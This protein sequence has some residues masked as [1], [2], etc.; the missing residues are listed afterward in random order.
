[1][2]I[3]KSDK[4]A[5]IQQQVDMAVNTLRQQH[6]LGPESVELVLMTGGMNDVGLPD[7][8]DPEVGTEVLRVRTREIYQTALTGDDG[9]LAKT[10]RVFPKAKIIYAGN[11]NILSNA[12]SSEVLLD[13]FPFSRAKSAEDL[14]QLKPQLVEQSTAFFEESNKQIKLAISKLEKSDQARLKFVIPDFKETDSIQRGK[15][16]YSTAQPPA[17]YTLNELYEFDEMLQARVE[18]CKG[19]VFCDYGSVGHPT[20]VGAT[21]YARAIQKA[22]LPFMPTWIISGEMSS[23][24]KTGQ[25]KEKSVTNMYG[26][27]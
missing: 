27:L 18:I 2:H 11:Y 21:K 26:G 5:A 14:H 3:N 25:K 17:L 15:V 23:R 4:V 8:L 7:I 6:D 10:A 13:I 9:L 19:D 24:N 20:R 1:V 16:N 22:I 12:S